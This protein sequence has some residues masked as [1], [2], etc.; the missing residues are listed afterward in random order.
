MKAATV[1]FL[2]SG[3]CVSAYARVYACVSLCVCVLFVS[4]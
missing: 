2:Q 3:V 4:G 1:L